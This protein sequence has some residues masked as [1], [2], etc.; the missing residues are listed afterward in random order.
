[1]HL[2][3]RMPGTQAVI[4]AGTHIFPSLLHITAM[5]TRY[6]CRTPGGATEEDGRRDPP[7]QSVRTSQGG[8][9]WGK[10]WPETSPT[11]C[12]GRSPKDG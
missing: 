2:S 9:R 8:V 4:Y 6:K 1:M 12:P 11:L 7:S 3:P 5:R 10:E